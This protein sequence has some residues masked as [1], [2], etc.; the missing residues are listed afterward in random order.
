MSFARTAVT[1]FAA[2][3][4]LA[5]PAT[6]VA[7]AGH[8]GDHGAK[9]EHK[10]AHGKKHGA[11]TVSLLVRGTWSGGALEVTGGNRA[12]RRAGLV[13]ESVTLGLSGARL[14]VRDRDGDG[15]RDEADLRDGDR[16]VVQARVPRGADAGA[17]L[18]VR[19]LVAR[20]KGGDDATGGDEAE[21][22]DDDTGAPEPGDDSGAD[23]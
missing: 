5:L 16:V 4:A 3:A 8:G 20:A 22:G 7:H 13:G 23:A 10:G 6:A 17:E 18:T 12:T 2:V 9:Q 19:K 1:T 14:R 15:D 11:R 21:P